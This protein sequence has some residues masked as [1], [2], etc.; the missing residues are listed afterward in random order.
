V[1]L[2][3][4]YNAALPSGSAVSGDLYALNQ[5]FDGLE[6]YALMHDGSDYNAALA[7][8]NTDIQALNGDCG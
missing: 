2:K 5:D 1:Q 8:A 7:Q 6:N 3:Q 4:A